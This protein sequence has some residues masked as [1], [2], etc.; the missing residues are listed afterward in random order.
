MLYTDSAQDTI[1]YND[2]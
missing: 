2:R 1:S